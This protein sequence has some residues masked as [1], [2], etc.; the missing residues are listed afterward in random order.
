MELEINYKLVIKQADGT[1]LP[2]KNYSVTIS[3]F[4]FAIQKNIVILFED[5]E[6]NANNYSVS[7]KSEKAQGAGTLLIDT[8]DFENFWSEYIKLAAAKKIILILI[9]MKKKKS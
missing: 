6:I 3:E 9:T 7:F 2:A 5:K 8:Y 1:T 4:L